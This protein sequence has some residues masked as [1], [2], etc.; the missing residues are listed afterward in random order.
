MKQRELNQEQKQSFGGDFKSADLTVPDIS[1]IV[2]ETAKDVESSHA[3]CEKIICPICHN[4]ECGFSTVITSMVNSG[5]TVAGIVA[6][7]NNDPGIVQAMRN[8]GAPV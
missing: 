4:T 3:W 8:A 2:A 5:M 1:E 6:Y 7:Y